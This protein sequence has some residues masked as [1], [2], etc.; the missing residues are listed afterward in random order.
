[1]EACYINTAHPDFLNGHQA[2]AM[3]NEQLSSKQQNQQQGH[4]ATDSAKST[5][6]HQQLAS[7]QT[8]GSSPQLDGDNSGS[9]FGSFFSGP[10]KTKKMAG[11]ME[12]VSWSYGLSA[13]F[14][15]L[16]NKKC[17]HP[18][19]LKPLVPFLSANTWRPKLSVSADIR[20]WKACKYWRFLPRTFDTILLQHC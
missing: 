8:G 17:S 12:A 9:F 2:I 14:I 6:S 15:T 3:V 7:L 13:A 20:S 4:G 1:M 16:V 18:H 10:K 19:P 5:R 11:L